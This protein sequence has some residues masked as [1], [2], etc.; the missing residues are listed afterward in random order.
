MNVRLDRFYNHPI[1]RVWEVLTAEEKLAQ[2]WQSADFKPE[3]GYRF[4]I[5]DEPQGGWDGTLQGEVLTADQPH[6]LEY[7]WHGDQM[8]NVTVVKWML[9]SEG[10]GTRLR[11]EHTGFKGLRDSVIG[12]FHRSG[13]G[14]YLDHLAEQMAAVQV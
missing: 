14:K 9:E 8:N 4:T 11:L 13:W 1:E 7:T 6:T 5:K 3:V 10:E 12:L 2:W